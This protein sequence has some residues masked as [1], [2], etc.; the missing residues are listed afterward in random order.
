MTE[1]PFKIGD[2]VYL[3]SQTEI[4]MCIHSYVTKV[5]YPD[6]I[7]F[8]Y[9]AYTELVLCH[10][11]NKISGLFTKEVFHVNQLIKK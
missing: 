4:T 11:L 8:N 3:K 2:V 10:Y 5:V 6:T 9:D 7:K 1:N